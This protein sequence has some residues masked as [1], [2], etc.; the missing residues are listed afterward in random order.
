[1]TSAPISVRDAYERARPFALTILVGNITAVY[2]TNVKRMLA[3]SSIAHAGYMLLPLL[4][5][6]EYAQGSLF[7]YAVAYS[8]S[9]LAAFTVLILVSGQGDETREAFR[10]LAWRS[11]WLAAVTLVALL[12]LAGIPPLA[13]FFAKYYVF[14]AALQNR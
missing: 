13:G 3:Y 12:S 1:M 8:L 14:S 6:N 9:S 5:M 7:F 4:A 10:G 2:Q 11:P